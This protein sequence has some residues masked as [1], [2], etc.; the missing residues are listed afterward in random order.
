MLCFNIFNIKEET[1]GDQFGRGLGPCLDEL[2]FPQVFAPA[3]VG[4]LMFCWR[5]LRFHLPVGNSFA[6]F[7]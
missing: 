3:Q 5:F 6:F 1:F 2:F 4:Q 7:G